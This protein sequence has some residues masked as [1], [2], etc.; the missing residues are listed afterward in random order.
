MSQLESR[1]VRKNYIRK[2][3]PK[4]QWKNHMQKAINMAKDNEDNAEEQIYK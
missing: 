4:T 3:G 1:T 2:T